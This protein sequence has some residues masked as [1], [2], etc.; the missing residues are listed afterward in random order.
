[1]PKAV[2]FYAAFGLRLRA[3]QPIVGLLPIPGRPEIDVEISLDTGEQGWSSLC[4]GTQSCLFVSNYLDRRGQPV[5][6]VW[7]VGRDAHFWFRYSDG[8]EFVI[9]R[10]GARIWGRRPAPAADED[11]AWFLLGPILGFVL[12]LRGVMCLHA[13]AVVV[14][15]HALVLM[16][17]RGAGKSTTAAMFARWGY[18][19]LADDVL[20]IREQRGTM[21]AFPSVPCLTLWPEA[22]QY[23]YGA[24]DALPR[25]APVESI[26]PAYD[27]R[28]LNLTADGYHFQSEPVP[29]GAIYILSS[30]R[31]PGAPR[32]EPL[33]GGSGMMALARNTYRAELLDKKMQAQEF[34][35]LGRL[36][37][38]I[39]LRQVTPSADLAYFLRLGEIILEDFQAIPPSTPLPARAGSC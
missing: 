3:D 39:P 32:L 16:G 33:A 35:A 23:L 8:I 19:V 20:S 6:Q 30:P 37:A 21:C 31:R 25:L 9:D 27:K 13:S 34:E 17:P 36:A 38:T 1:M 29:L 7:E 26:D 18:P 10:Q 2:W 28:R 4:R 5:L 12:R 15:R 11:M 14:G 22:V 24:P